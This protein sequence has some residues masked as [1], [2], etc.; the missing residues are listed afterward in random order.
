MQQEIKQAQIDFESLAVIKKFVLDLLKKER[1]EAYLE[2]LE[3][4]K[5]N[6]EQN[7]IE[8]SVGE[9]TIYEKMDKIT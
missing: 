9:P 8:K 3:E 7:P 4:E 6:L 1:P 2:Y 5:A